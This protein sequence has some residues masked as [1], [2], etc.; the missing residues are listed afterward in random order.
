[1]RIDCVLK[2]RGGGG[3]KGECPVWSA[4]EQCLYWVDIDGGTLNRF[5]PATGRNAAYTLGEPIGCHGLRRAGGFVLATRSGVHLS[6]ADPTQR[7]RIAAPEPDKPENR[8]NDGRCDP[9]GR[10]WFGTMCDPPTRSADPQGGLY[11]VDP[12]GTATRMVDGIFVGNGLAFSP[13]GR[14]LY[15]SDSF[16][17]VRTIWAWDLDPQG[18]LTNRRVFATTHGL[19][20]RPDGACVDAD[21]C[22][23]SCH[24]DGGLVVRYTPDGRIDRT[25]PMPVKWPTMCAFGG[26]K[27]DTLYITSLR[28]GGAA[29]EHPDQPL[30]GSLFA[31]RPGVT[32]VPEPLFGG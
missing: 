13:D 26:A 14:I 11:R 5:D 32:G 10:F 17:A 18:G 16:A 23:W 28:R 12:D 27:L 7:T 1:M 2:M 25:I 9:Q 29:A 3:P 15:H 8:P 31:C 30:A 6:G 20:G 24:I 19:Q 4:A 21:G 22:Y